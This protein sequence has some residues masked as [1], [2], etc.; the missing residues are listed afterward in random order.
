[1]ELL[2]N[3]LYMMVNAERLFMVILEELAVIYREGLG[4]LYNG[5]IYRKTII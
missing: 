3:E 2:P 4:T 1:M 5:E